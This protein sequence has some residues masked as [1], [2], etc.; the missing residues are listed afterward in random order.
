MASI[1]NRPAESLASRRAAT[2]SHTSI[3]SAA[4]SCQ[5]SAF[6]NSSASAMRVVS[7][8]AD[9]TAVCKLVVPARLASAELGQTEVEQQ[10]RPRLMRWRFQQGPA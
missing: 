10:A 1:V 5:R 4:R 7:S 3:A 2:P 8:P 6:A 9:S